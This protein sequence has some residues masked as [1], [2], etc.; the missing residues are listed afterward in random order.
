MPDDKDLTS[1]L[2]GRVV[3]FLQWDDP[4]MT[5]HMIAGVCSKSPS[6]KTDQAQSVN[7]LTL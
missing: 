3:D 1:P 6:K 7:S 4:F 5:C 2:F